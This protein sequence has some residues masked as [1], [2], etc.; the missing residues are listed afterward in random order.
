M[1]ESALA[2]RFT[3][4]VATASILLGAAGA[5]HAAACGEGLRPAMT[6]QLF[7]G[8]SA[9]TEGEVTDADWRAFVDA[10][11]TPRFPD[12][13]TVSDVYGQWRSPAG[14]F[15]HE[16]TKAVFIVLS[17]RTDER[18]RLEL[19]RSAYKRRFHQQSVLLVEQRA[20]VAF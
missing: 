12:G 6:A 7:F 2:L 5:T 8:R 1:R 20:C 3:L 19:I 17:G 14:D 4:A 11:V 10:E 9:G 15:V 18:Q 13:L 16:D